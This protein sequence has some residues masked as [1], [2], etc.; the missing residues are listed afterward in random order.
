MS[1]P[2]LQFFSCREIFAFFTS[3]LLI[4]SCTQF[5]FWPVLTLKVSAQSVVIPRFHSWTIM[6][7]T[8]AITLFVNIG[9]LFHTCITLFV[10]MLNI[11]ASF[12]AYS[13]SLLRTFCHSLQSALSNMSS[14]TEF[15]SL[16]SDPFWGRLEDVQTVWV[17]AQLFFSNAVVAAPLWNQNLFHFPFY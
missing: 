4:I 5:S 11:I 12:N 6:S 2:G 15:S 17:P 10:P 9:L 3:P 8:Q 7:D 1:R 14:S 16:C 13:P